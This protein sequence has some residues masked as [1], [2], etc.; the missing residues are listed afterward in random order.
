LL[1]GAFGLL[2][3]LVWVV[4]LDRFS[5]VKLLIVTTLFMTAALLVQSVLWAV[6]TKESDPNPNALRA[7]VAMFFVFQLGFVA[8]GYVS[9]PSDSA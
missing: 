3:A 9:Q 4:S 2:S 8:V 1:Y 5:R 6:Y 7:Q